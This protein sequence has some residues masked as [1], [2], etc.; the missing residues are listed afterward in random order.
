MTDNRTEDILGHLG[1]LFVI[2]I[3][4]MYNIWA[5]WDAL[6]NVRKSWGKRRTRGVAW[7]ELK[8]K[9]KALNEREN[10]GGSRTAAESGHQM[11]VSG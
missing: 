4:R 11:F 9:V 10:S 5:L 7:E 1:P 8:T 6:Q 3:R 2:I